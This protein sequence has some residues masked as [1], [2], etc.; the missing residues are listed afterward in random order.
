MSLAWIIAGAVVLVAL[1]SVT[2]LLRRFLF[3]FAAAAGAL[4]VL[5]MQTNPAEAGTALAAMGGGVAFAGPFRRL[6]FRTIL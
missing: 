2:R 4:L 3:A 6:I 1:V 5:H